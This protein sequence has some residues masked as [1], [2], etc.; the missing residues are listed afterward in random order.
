MNQTDVI[1]RLQN[2][3]DD[4]LLDPTNLTPET[5][6]KEVPE[7]DSLMHISILVAIEKDFDIRFRIGEVEKTKNVGEFAD[8]ILLRKQS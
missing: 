8:L 5:T 3:F 6:A 4:L 1:S 7:W 2:I